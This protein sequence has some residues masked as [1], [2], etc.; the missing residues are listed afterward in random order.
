[1]PFAVPGMFHIAA[2]PSADIRGHYT[3]LQHLGLY[4]AVP[5]D[6]DWDLVAGEEALALAQA[7]HLPS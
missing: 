5:E 2:A 6:M 1:M 7:G 4:S 3:K